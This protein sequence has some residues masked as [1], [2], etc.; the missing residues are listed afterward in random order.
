MVA[1]KKRVEDKNIYVDEKLLE[2][3]ALFEISRSLTSSLSIRSILENILRIPMGHLL[4]T[5][6]IVLLKA[7]EQNNY[8]VEELKGINRNLKSKCI[9]ITYPPE[10]VQVIS[11]VRHNTEWADFFREFGIEIVLPLNTSQGIIGIVGYGSKIGKKPFVD[12]EIEF[13]N[14]LSNI[15]A[16]A[17]ANGLNVDELRKVNRN[18]DRKV[19][20]L[21]T[22]FDISQEINTTLDQEKIGSIVAFA[23][24]GELMV[25]KCA[26]FF[27]GE[28]KF[29]LVTAKGISCDKLDSVCIPVISDPLFFTS[30]KDWNELKESGFTLLVPMRLQEKA[31]GAIALGPK[32]NNSDFSDNDIDFLK[33]L[34]NQAAASLEN[35]RLFTEALEKQ[36]M[37]EELKLARSMQQGLL[38]AKL[39]DDIFCEFAATN[40]PSREVG[41]DY[42]D[43][44]RIDENIWGVAIA[45]VSGKGAGAALLMANLQASLNVLAVEEKDDVSETVGRINR[46]IFKN[47]ALD[48]FITFFYGLINTKD[49][50]LTFCNAGHN[51]P[52]KISPSGG[53]TELATGGIVLGMMENVPY[54]QETVSFDPGDKLV[55]YTDGVTEAMDE[56]GEE[57]GEEKLKSIITK[58]IDKN[59]IQLLDEIVRN[60]KEYE[61][62]D[63]QA[64]DI[65]VVIV[66]RK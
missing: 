23:I 8:R 30:G 65:T 52:Y 39:P 46:L 33:I 10:D 22:I 5:R 11:E 62:G 27:R 58:S 16:T 17:V 38:P 66:R 41:G 55:L 12:R 32:I 26:V 60:V 3:S 21:N 59:G 29:R 9:S 63:V 19:Q 56:R 24:M 20:Q 34:G 44:I 4:I 48:K 7:G 43:V 6:G 51:P 53:I 64:D 47:T 40:I 18:L 35:V 61:H 15:A 37:E 57:F 31:V 14:S 49:N 45:D 50:T 2:L 28:D 25:N 42:Y 36:R 13:L 1:E 54:Q